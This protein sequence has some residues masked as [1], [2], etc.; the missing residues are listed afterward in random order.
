MPEPTLLELA[1]IVNGIKITPLSQSNMFFDKAND[2]YQQHTAWAA[3]GDG[4]LVYD[5]FGGP[6]TQANQ[7]DFTLWD[8]GAYRRRPRRQRKMPAA[9]HDIVAFHDKFS[10]SGGHQLKF[11]HEYA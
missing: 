11:H 2:G 7:V 1:I 8:P 6:V 10:V 3:P 9:L 5:P 4:V